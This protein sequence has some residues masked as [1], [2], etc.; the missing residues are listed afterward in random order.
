MNREEAKNQFSNEL[1]DIIFK[2]NNEL[3]VGGTY[4]I[5]DEIYNDFES[6]ICKN[7][8]YFKEFT[9]EIPFTEGLKID[10]IGCEL[11]EGNFGKNFGC[12]RFE[13]RNK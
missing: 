1:L 4:K 7:C 12:N 9:K 10:K 6:R 5:I 2:R 3:E 8:K 11:F 13:R